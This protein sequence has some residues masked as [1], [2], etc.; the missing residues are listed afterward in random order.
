M[1]SLAVLLLGRAVM[2]I[3]PPTEALHNLLIQRAVQSCCYTARECRD[4][5]TAQWLGNFLGHK[6]LEGY[7]GIDGL[8]VSW[9]VYF[10]E[11]LAA[12]PEDLVVQSV[13]MRHRGLSPNNPFLKPTPMEYTHRIVPSSLAERVMGAARLIA[14]EWQHDLLLLEAENAEHWEV[15]WEMVREKEDRG[16]GS[17]Q[18]VFS[19]DPDHAE[20]PYRGGNYDLLKNLATRNAVREYTSELERSRS[21]GH[22]HLFLQRFCVA[23]PLEDD[24]DSHR[25]DDFLLALLQTPFAIV[26]SSIAD[27]GDGVVSAAGYPQLIDPLELAREVMERR[28][29]LAN[30]WAAELE[31]F[32]DRLLAIQR[33][34]LLRASGTV[35]DAE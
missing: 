21:C 26:G 19:L 35:M 30:S 1:P 25:A 15:H 13:L 14:R 16:R 12:P 10:Q 27:N 31:D 3:V 4:N 28:L 17:R 5:P 22:T 7:H 9:K 32:P 29:A 34:H 2:G 18:P 8:R 20:S 6:G 11:L 24:G 23:H 33:G